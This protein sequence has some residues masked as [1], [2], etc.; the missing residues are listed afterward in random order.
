MST[1]ARRPKVFAYANFEIDALISLA[2]SLRGQS[3]TVDTS[4]RPRA[5]STRW[6]VFVTFEDGV[7][8]VPIATER[9][10]RHYHRRICVQVTYQRG[11][12]SKVSEDP[13]FDTGTRSVLV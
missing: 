2:T 5:G 12:D 13:G 9:T 3:C 11:F 4:T 6:V 7:E 1:K 10:E 8:W